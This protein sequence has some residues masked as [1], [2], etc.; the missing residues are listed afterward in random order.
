MEGR[1]IYEEFI[2]WFRRSGAYAPESDA[3]LPLIEATYTSDEA[4]L[5]TGMPLGLTPLSELADIKGMDPSV[6]GSFLDGMA[7][8][9]LVYRIREEGVSKYRPN[10]PRFVYLRALFWPGRHDL[11]TQAV[12]PRVTRYYLDGF[13]DHWK[14]VITK[15]MR[16]IP[17]ERSI[18]D[19][20]SILPYEKVLHLLEGQDRFA[21]AHC[22]CRHRKNTD[23]DLPDCTHETENCL[24][25]GRLAHY[26]I[27][28]SLGREIDLAE[29]KEI[30]GRAAEE[31]LV[32]AASNWQ[33]NVD[34][35]C[36]CCEC[37]C[38]YFQAFHVLK[39]TGSMSPS[40][41]RVH[42]TREICIGCGRCV[43]RCPMKA[44]S[45]VDDPGASNKT[46]KVCNINTQYCIGCGVCAY[47][48]PTDSLTLRRREEVTHPPVDVSELKA[49]YA[50]ESASTRGKNRLGTP[51]DVSSGEAVD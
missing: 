44:L 4:A 3:L 36:N 45:L 24:H 40:N 46:G 43:E 21:V 7:G 32:H 51:A 49:R 26:I 17:V 23:P 18:E 13:G 12:S 47:K 28:N 33:E 39:H 19:P 11:Y 25:F 14:D 15:G 38:V 27:G 2:E 29:C 35:I 50:A 1:K 10:P 34:T 22:A 9:G 20:R 16:A 37:C 31:G 5:L 6:L 48:C 8:R 30:L 42:V 41:Y